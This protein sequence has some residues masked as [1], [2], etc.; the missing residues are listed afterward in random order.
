M[1]V[2]VTGAA[3]FAGAH[4][5]RLLTGRGCEVIASDRRRPG[6]GS[7]AEFVPCDITD[8]GAVD[9]LAA[10]ARPD[11]VVHL[12]AVSSVRQAATD[13]DLAHKVNVQGTRNLLDS[14]VRHSPGARFIGISSAAVYGRVPEEDQP[15]SESRPP[16]PSGAYAVTKASVEELCRSYSDRLAVVVLRPFNHIGPGQSADFVTA[17]F[18]RQIAMIEAGRVEPIIRTGN[19]DTHRDFT[20]VRDVAAA[21]LCAIEKARTDETCNICSGTAVSIREMLDDL[22]AMS[23]ADI[24]VEPDSARLRSDDI[25]LVCGCPD[26]FM[27]VTGWKPRIE[28]I[29]SLE[30]ILDYWRERMRKA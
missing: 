9:S 19:L 3:G 21:Y 28:L 22:L 26:K 5:V 13:A 2:L 11:A 4:L 29:K 14:I 27:Q 17:S 24:R 1:R 12:A 15:I 30:D 16:A 25:P 8:G 23:D 10:Q 20:D 7:D 6:D 18:A